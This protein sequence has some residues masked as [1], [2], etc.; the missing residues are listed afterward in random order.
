MTS[1][2]LGSY[3]KYELENDPRYLSFRQHCSLTR[4]QIQQ[5]ELYFLVPPQQR[6]KARYL[7]VDTCVH[8]AEQALRYQQQGDFSQIS[9]AFLLDD[10]T[11]SAVADDLEEQTL[12]QLSAMDQ[13][14]Y[15]DAQTFSST[16]GQHIAP[17]VLEQQGAAICQAADVGRRRFQEK[18]GW[19]LDYK[20]DYSHLCPTGRNRS[21]RGETSQATRV[22]PSLASYLCRKYQRCAVSA[23]GTTIHATSD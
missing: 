6:S 13:K 16:L 12:I 23:S 18:L 3:L 17:E 14:A 22:E 7:N 10:K 5:T 2:R 4:Q 21:H 15:P 11:V 20:E 19:L 1:T 8:W 9:P